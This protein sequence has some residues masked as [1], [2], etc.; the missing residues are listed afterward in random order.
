MDTNEYEQS[1]EQGKIVF[2]NGRDDPHF[3]KMQ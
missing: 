1:F 2:S 3:E